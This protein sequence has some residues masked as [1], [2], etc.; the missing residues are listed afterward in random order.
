M[1]QVKYGHPNICIIL[2]ETQD[3]TLT[4]EVKSK[5][6]AS[7]LK[8]FESLDQ[9]SNKEMGQKM[10]KNKFQRLLNANA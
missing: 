2:E 5:F 7:V 8:G 10:L 9:K 6:P 1:L 4:L 3:K